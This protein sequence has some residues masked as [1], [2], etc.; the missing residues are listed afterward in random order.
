MVMNPARDNAITLPAHPILLPMGGR[1]IH[2][3]YA[4]HGYLSGVPAD[5]SVLATESIDGEPALDKPTFI[6]YPS[7]KGRVVA[8][9]Q[10]FHDRDNSG[11]GPLMQTVL[12]YATEKKWYAKN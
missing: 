7:G 8:A 1:T 6:E 10:C 9:C 4:S 2:A 3:N 11:R 12:T 5:A